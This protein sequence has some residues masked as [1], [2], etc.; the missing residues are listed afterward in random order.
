LSWVHRLIH[1]F[2]SPAVAASLEIHSRQWIVRCR[3]CGYERSIW[4]IGGVRWKAW[5]TSYT[6]GGCPQCG[7]RGWHTIFRRNPPTAAQ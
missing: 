4:E 7:K 6:W 1:R 5:G 3:S 2:A